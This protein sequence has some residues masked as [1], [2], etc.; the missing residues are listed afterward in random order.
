MTK[1]IYSLI[2]YILNFKNN[3]AKFIYTYVVFIFFSTSTAFILPLYLYQTNYTSK[4]QLLDLFNRL[5]LPL[6]V[7]YFVYLVFNRILESYFYLRIN[8]TCSKITA[9]LVSKFETGN[10]VIDNPDIYRLQNSI[11]RFNNVFFEF[12]TSSISVFIITPIKICIVAYVAIE[13]FSL[14]TI[15]IVITGS[16]I[17]S[18]FLIAMSKSIVKSHIDLFDSESIYSESVSEL[19]TVADT[20]IASKSQKFTS[21]YLGLKKKDYL[22]NLKLAIHHRIRS[23]I[24]SASI[25]ITIGFFSYLY[26]FNKE[27]NLDMLI[28]LLYLV[29]IVNPIRESILYFQTSHEKIEII[30][31]VFNFELI[32]K[33]KSA[34]KSGKKEYIYLKNLSVS[35]CVNLSPYTRCLG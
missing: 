16:I 28:S 25:F 35:L 22:N 30:N 8:E 19:I 21:E 13:F 15:L 27:I 3:S 12:I 32:E 26:I 33:C 11:R 9:N 17:V 1:V 24:I 14:G 4:L 31:S 5:L 29:C 23:D 20:T 18:F 7:L 34:H 10:Y 2:D 6:L